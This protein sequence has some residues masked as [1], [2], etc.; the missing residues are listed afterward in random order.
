VFG[1]L[2]NSSSTKL[3]L[4]CTKS[5]VG[6]EFA[7]NTTGGSLEHFSELLFG[8]YR[9]RVE[10][11]GGDLGKEV[12]EVALEVDNFMRYINLLTYLLTWHS[13]RHL[14]RRLL[15]LPTSGFFSF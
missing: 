2:Q 3:E 12:P 15:G 14:R 9:S 5:M 6:G 8:F 4:R 7:P 10:G 1:D 13:S 11:N